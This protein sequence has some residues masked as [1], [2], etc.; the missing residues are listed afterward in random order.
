MTRIDMGDVIE[1]LARARR[2][3]AFR[4]AEKD[5]DFVAVCLIGP[6]RLQPR[7]IGSNAVWWPTSV[8]LSSDWTKAADRSDIE[9]WADDVVV[10]RHTWCATKRHATRLKDEIVRAIQGDDPDMRHRR[11]NWIDW[12]EWETAWDIVVEDA[13][14]VCAMRGEEIELF[15]D[16]QRVGI[17]WQHSRR[18]LKG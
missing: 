7:E 2:K 16:G 11:R 3:T 12:P 17:I 10:L 18:I 8:R 5:A 9:N 6:T 15:D 13:I 4:V 1:Q 14:R